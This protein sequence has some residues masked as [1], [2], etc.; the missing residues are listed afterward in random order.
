MF[1]HFLEEQNY[2]YK[3]NSALRHGE[4]P[5][6]GG[7]R[8]A[9]IVIEKQ[10]DDCDI[11]DCSNLILIFRIDVAPYCIPNQFPTFETPEVFSYPICSN[12]K[13]SKK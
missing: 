12:S 9:T 3:Y 13:K 5:H 1:Y 2:N 11:H 7:L 8:G 4:F 6:Y 10:L